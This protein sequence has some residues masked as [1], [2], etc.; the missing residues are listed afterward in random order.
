M[1][2]EPVAII[3]AISEFVRT[4]ILLGIA[5]GLSVTQEQFAAIMIF[6]GSLLALI[7]TIV[8]RRKVSPQESI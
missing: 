6:V 5:F 4:A 2:N 3:N 1:K 8:V 7:S